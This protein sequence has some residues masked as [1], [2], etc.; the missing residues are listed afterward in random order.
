MAADF[1]VLMI[2]L[3]DRLHNLQTLQFVL[4]EKQR[5]IALES[6]E[7]YAPL[8]HRLGIGKLKGE[9][10]DAAFPYAYPKEFTDIE[11]FMDGKKQVSESLV[12]S[13]QSSLERELNRQHISIIK[14]SHR[15]KHKYSL[16]KK[17]QRYNNA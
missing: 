16:W 17:L 8:A 14:M 1:R 9:I 7:I 13:V 3:A 12:A 11:K 4:P 15:I 2:K 5:R 6:I 10:E